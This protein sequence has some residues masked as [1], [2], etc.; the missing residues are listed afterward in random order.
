MTMLQ[1]IEQTREEKIKMYMKIPKK[2]LIEML[3]NCNEIIDELKK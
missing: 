3:I 1:V 2:A